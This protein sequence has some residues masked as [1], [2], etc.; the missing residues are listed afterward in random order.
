[1]KFV[2]ATL[3]MPVTCLIVTALIGLM[4]SFYMEL[5]RQISENAAR[6]DEIYETREVS[7]IRLRDSITEVLPRPLETDS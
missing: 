2:E 5:D 3:I 7:V 1:M 6:R 4:M